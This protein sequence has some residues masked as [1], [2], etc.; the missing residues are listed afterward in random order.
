MTVK[1]FVI[2]GA[3]LGLLG[4]REPD[5]Y[6]KQSLQQ[7]EEALQAEAERLGVE[8]LMFQTDSEARILALLHRARHEAQG[9]II[10]PGAH[11]HYSVAIRDA[12]AALDIPKIEVHITN[13]HAREGFRSKSITGSA[14]NG[15]ITGLGTVGYILAIE[16]LLRM[17]KP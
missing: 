12:L 5:K 14:V 2:N 6:G 9:V 3:N 8:L 16:A 15:V 7:L 11:T 1:V 17:I 13:I 4:D 10:N